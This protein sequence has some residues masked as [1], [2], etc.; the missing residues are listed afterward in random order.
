MSK[1]KDQIEGE[2]PKDFYTKSLENLSDALDEK[3]DLY[4]LN[5]KMIDRLIENTKLTIKYIKR[6]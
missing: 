2:N 1:T 4:D 5:I 6:I 3:P